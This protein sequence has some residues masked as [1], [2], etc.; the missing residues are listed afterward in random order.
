VIYGD[1]PTGDGELILVVDDE[2]A[3]QE[4]TKATLEIHGK[5]YSQKHYIKNPSDHES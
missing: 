5:R 3:T 2:V 4:I 1:I